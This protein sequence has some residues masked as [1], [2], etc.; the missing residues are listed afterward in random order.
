MSKLKSRLIF[1]KTPKTAGTS[2]EGFLRKSLGDIRTIRI[3]G[4]SRHF[5][6]EAELADKS[7][8]IV[9]DIVAQAFKTECPNI[10]ASSNTFGVVRDPYSKCVS[11]WR[12]CQST[13]SRPLSDALRSPPKKRWW[14]RYNHDYVHF[15][16][17]QSDFL[18]GTDGKLMVGRLL[19]FENLQSEIKNMFQ[20]FGIEGACLPH[21]NVSDYSTG[22]GLT[23]EEVAL[24]N[25][26]YSMDFYCF[27][28][29][30]IT[31]AV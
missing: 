13:R 8:I 18:I 26:R 31:G 17:R 22:G 6:S 9:G 14:R 29:D 7:A 28:Y 10:W 27:G 2:I 1:L 11:A 21:Y 15:T 3:D 4:L 24:I 25:N 30:R 5:P 12:Y 23:G 19:R 20:A 16:M